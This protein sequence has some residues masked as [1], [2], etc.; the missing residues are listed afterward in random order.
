MTPRYWALALLVSLVACG[1]NPTTQALPTA[2][3]LRVAAVSS[4]DA[5][6]IPATYTPSPMPAPPSTPTSTL[7]PPPTPTST[8]AT[9]LDQYRLWMEEARAKY[10]YGESIEVMWNLMLCESSGNADVVAGPYHGLFQ[11]DMPTW[12][13][14]WNP[15]RDNSIFDPHAQ[16]FATAKA[17]SE[18]NIDWWGACV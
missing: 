2:H 15:Y 13:G 10:P 5:P 8:F 9:P 1:S 7:A 14:D 16:I 18:G 6:V 4:R 11:Y 12:S 3:I 17:W